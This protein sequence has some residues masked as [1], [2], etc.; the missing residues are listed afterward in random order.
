ME[1]LMSSEG[2]VPLHRTV[3]ESFPSYGSP[4]VNLLYCLTLKAINT[5]ND[6]YSLGR[7]LPWA[8]KW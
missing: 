7:D 5:N 8:C 4:V 3:R 2:S 1:D 6:D